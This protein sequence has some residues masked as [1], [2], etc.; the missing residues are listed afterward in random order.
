MIATKQSAP[1]PRSQHH[2]ASQPKPLLQA[3]ANPAA[4]LTSQSDEASPTHQSH[5]WRPPNGSKSSASVVPKPIPASQVK[6]SRAFQ[7]SQLERRFKVTKQQK[8]DG[9]FDLGFSLIPTDPDF[10]FDLPNGLEC[11]LHL[12][13][14]YPVSWH[15]ID[16]PSLLVQNKE[17]GEQWRRS[18]ESGFRRLVDAM[19]PNGT[20]LSLLNR[21]D[22]ELE[23]LL[24]EKK[25]EM[26]TIV[27][28][29][30]KGDLAGQNINSRPAPLGQSN[31]TVADPS[32][33]YTAEQIETAAQHRATEIRQLEARLGRL[34]GFSKSSDG[35]AYTIPITPRNID[36]LPRSLQVI[37]KVLL[38]VPKLYPLHNCRVE[39]QGASNDVRKGVEK[40][41]ERKA[42][43]EDGTL[44]GRTNMLVQNMHL[45]A[46]EA[47]ELD[48]HEPTVTSDL[49]HL[50]LTD[51]VSRWEKPVQSDEDRDHIVIIPRP[52]E[53]NTQKGDDT[54]SDSEDF[55]SDNSG[56]S[57]AVDEATDNLS[58]STHAAPL[59]SGPERGISLSFP[60][61]E[62]HSIELLELV[63]LCIVIKCL[64]CKT[65][66]DMNSLRDQKPRDDSCKKCASRFT[67]CFRRELIH[68]N[69]C[70]AGYLDLDGCTVLEMLPSTFLPTCSHCSTTHPTPGV[71]SVRGAS[72]MAIC[73]E[74]H[75][76]MTLK[77][78]ETKFL[79]VSSASRSG[80]AP[81]RRKRPKEN[82]GIT[83]GQELPRRGR[84]QHYGKSYRWFRFS[85]CERVFACDRCHDEA[86]DHPNE[87]ANR[88]ICGLCSREQNYRPADCGVCKASMIKKAGTG[89]WEGGTGTRD[90]VRM[91]RKG[92]STS[93]INIRAIWKLKA[94]I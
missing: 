69:A 16:K 30:T 24:T 79:L 89:F 19:G 11:V 6:D 66:I 55:D 58:Q 68:H 72:T 90:K 42:K 74:C 14:A 26:V 46:M 77:I 36:N 43:W 15:G 54:S 86:S 84:C 87:H 93:S 88:M 33:S 83:V 1:N 34:P 82:L 45:L 65:T 49:R 37:K 41:F 51:N 70:K 60:Y 38:F 47:T 53:W 5:D 9:A 73:R 32:T 10:P 25:P 92:K 21:L 40:V 91:S 80:D 78:P 4:P 94:N 13:A 62:L 48:S 56:H 7:I 39:L 23:G 64:R 59:T 20:L 35:I 22:R 76:K 12:P 31:K 75:A 27:P 29:K 81:P 63:S 61:L 8:D 2:N 57:S 52:P 50:S 85:C 44:V 28:N 71:V 67:V 3:Q 18:V 17:M